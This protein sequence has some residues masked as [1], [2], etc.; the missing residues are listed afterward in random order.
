MKEC[1]PII[2]RSAITGWITV[3]CEQHEYSHSM[4]LFADA[5]AEA[6]I[7]RYETSSGVAL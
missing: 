1:E 4:L 5:V 3:D 2:Y 6:M 7:H